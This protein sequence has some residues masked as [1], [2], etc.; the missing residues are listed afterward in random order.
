M[1]DSIKL[2]NLLKAIDEIETFNDGSI[3]IKWRS[4][5]YHESPGHLINVADGSIVMKGYNVHLNPD[6]GES[7][8]NLEFK[9]VQSKLDDG[10]SQ[11]SKSRSKKTLGC[12]L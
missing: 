4:N 1:E 11:A 9:D 12:E 5:V 6:L 2:N 10:V 3:R 7:I 8:K